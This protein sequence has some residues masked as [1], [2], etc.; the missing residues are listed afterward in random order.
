MVPN[1]E[2][3]LIDLAAR[4]L[5]EKHPDRSFA[6]VSDAVT[7]A[8]AHFVGR[9][10][11]DFIPLLVER[12]AEAELSRQSPADLP[13]GADSVSEGGGDLRPVENGAHEPGGRH[14]RM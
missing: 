5:A 10:I 8:R 9:P 3:H 13:V 7:R 12:H 14:R 6:A 2:Q 11:R 1:E 4:R